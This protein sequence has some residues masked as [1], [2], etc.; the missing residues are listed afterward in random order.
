MQISEFIS[1]IYF[2]NNMIFIN[3]G[4][5]FLTID[6]LNSFL[7]TM[8]YVH[9]HFS[10]RQPYGKSKRDVHVACVSSRGERLLFIL[11]CH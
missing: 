10:A 5:S 4:D 11:E 6:D 2:L 3:P 8:Q 9:L 7:D 1:G